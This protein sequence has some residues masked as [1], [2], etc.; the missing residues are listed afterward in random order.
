MCSGNNGGGGSGGGEGRKM[1]C[2]GGGGEGRKMRCDGGGG[3]DG[4]KSID[5]GGKTKRD[6]T[7]GPHRLTTYYL[8]RGRV[9]VSEVA[10]DSEKKKKK[11][12]RKISGQAYPVSKVTRD[13]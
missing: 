13:L 3:G 1:R 11:Y 7:L 9:M 4:K 2:D 12:Y 8:A 10:G 6:Y 5:Y